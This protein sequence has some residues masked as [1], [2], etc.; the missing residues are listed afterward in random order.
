MDHPED[1]LID[2]LEVALNSLTEEKGMRFV[3]KVKEIINRN[4]DRGRVQIFIEGDMDNVN[5][6]VETVAN[7]YENLSPYLYQLQIEGNEEVWKELI[8]KLQKWAYSYFISRNFYPGKNTFEIAKIQATEAAI[9]VLNAHFP[10]DVDFNP[11]ARVLLVHTCQKYI[12]DANKK[13]TIPYKKL[14]SID[15]VFERGNIS[16]KNPIIFSEEK[17]D[18][19]EALEKI[20]DARRQ[21]LVMKYFKGKAINEIAEAMNRSVAA[22]Y[23]LHFN[24]INDLRK[25][26]GEKRDK[27]E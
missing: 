21:V 14:V 19:M 17:I 15:K 12:R 5:E 23:C 1:E 11:W 24:G 25:I 7:N 3:R 20:T 9:K 4:L 10:Y 18:L 13:S 22:I 8:N 6:Y 26:L 2:K 16:E 27:D